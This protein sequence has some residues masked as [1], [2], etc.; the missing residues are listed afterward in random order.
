M[1]SIRIT[2]LL[3]VLIPLQLSSI[4]LQASELLNEKVIILAGTEVPQGL[5]KFIPNLSLMSAG[6]DGKLKPIPFQIDEVDVEGNV[7]FAQ[8][9]KDV[10]GELE[11]LDEKD[12][13][14]F[15]WKDS[16]APL[17]E[18]TLNTASF[19][20][21]AEIA[22]TAI[23]AE[24]RYVYLVENSR[25]T[26]DVT[27]VRY[28]AD[29]GQIETDYY[30]LSVNPDNAVAWKEFNYFSYTGI[31]D[32]PIDS[33]KMRMTAGVVTR[34]AKIKLTNKNFTAKPI[35]YKTG[36]IR[37]TTLY[38]VTVKLF[39]VPMMKMSMQGHFFSNGLTYVTTAN[40]PRV[41]MTMLSKPTMSVSLD[42]NGLDGSKL[43]SAIEP[44]VSYTAN[45][46]LSD[47]EIA[48]KTLNF[49]QQK[50]WLWLRTEDNFNVFTQFQQTQGKQM[51]VGI[52]YN[53]THTL[54]D[55]PER[56]RGQVPNFGYLVKDFP[57]KGLFQLRMDVHF[58]QSM[59]GTS[60]QEYATATSTPLQIAS[61]EI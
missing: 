18:A 14:V 60:P 8:S 12:E 58:N 27:Y 20:I 49:D 22:V 56:F 61:R 34:F 42:C 47:D 37:S 30:S 1:L 3:T 4:N 29:L 55:K 51:P 57:K 24:T 21:L 19:E 31:E 26:S 35:A 32:S 5:G 28:S 25:L 52:H 38:K 45:G 7:Y 33:I 15:M 13:L 36:P 54:K 39:K 41:R 44:N 53:D 16:Q 23:G 17:S 48:L 2:L 59:Q 10:D 9:K 46:D 11:V 50:P 43:I 6:K 40:L